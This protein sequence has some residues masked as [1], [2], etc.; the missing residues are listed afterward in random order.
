MHIIKRV[1]AYILN[2]LGQAYGLWVGVGEESPIYMR[3]GGMPFP[4]TQ[5]PLPITINDLALVA[6]LLCSHALD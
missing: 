6:W 3:G 4:F 2:I 1:Q 5:A